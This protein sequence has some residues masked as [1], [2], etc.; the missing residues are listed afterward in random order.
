VEELLRTAESVT[1]EKGR[2]SQEFLQTRDDFIKV[3]TSEGIN[4]NAINLNRSYYLNNSYEKFKV[5]NL[6]GLMFDDEQ[7]KAYL[8]YEKIPELN[9]QVKYNQSKAYEL[10]GFVAN[11]HCIST[12]NYGVTEYTNWDSSDQLKRYLSQA[13]ADPGAYNI[14][15]SLHLRRDIYFDFIQNNVVGNNQSSNKI[16]N[17]LIHRD[18]SIFNFIETS[19][20][21]YLIDF[22]FAKFSCLADDLHTLIYEMI[23]Y[24][25][26]DVAASLIKGY[27]DGIQS[28]EYELFQT[29]HSS[30]NY[31][32]TTI[33]I[34]TYCISYL[35]S[36]PFPYYMKHKLSDENFKFLVDS[37][38]DKLH[39]LYKSFRKLP[40]KVQSCQ[41]DLK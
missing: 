5:I 20:A 35:C 19:Q 16:A 24:F 40:E 30:D 37:R 6:K 41:K 25:G 31:Y 10:G 32:H 7:D 23:H 12:A 28:S 21:S 3:V 9:S 34:L 4:H 8:I 18:L 38:N 13:A 2:T 15:H 1:P 39:T 14:Q 26:V 17:S 11:L 33:I 29:E 22:D 27:I 36:N